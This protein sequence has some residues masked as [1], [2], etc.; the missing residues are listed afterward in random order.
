MI[1]PHCDGPF[2]KDRRVAVVGG[3]NSGIEAAIDLAGICSYVTVLEFMPELKADVVL[4]QKVRSLPNVEVFTNV[5]TEDLTRS[6]ERR[7]GK[8]CRSRWSPYH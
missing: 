4:Q 3:G 1:Y 6:E 7:V 2:F 8:E 5:A